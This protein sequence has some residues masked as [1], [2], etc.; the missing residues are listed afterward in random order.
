MAK[1]K[2]KVF[3]NR[4]IEVEKLATLYKLGTFMNKKQG[5][6]LLCDCSGLIKG[7]LWDYPNDGEYES[8][9][10]PDINADTMISRCSNVSTDF[11]KLPYGSLVWLKGH[12]GVHIGNGVCIE[13]SPKWENGIQKT[14]IKGCGYSNSQGLPV[15]KWTKHGIFDKYIDYSEPVTVK[16]P[17]FYKKYNGNS[18][19]IDT[20]FKAIG[21]PYGNVEMRRLVAEKNGYKA[22]YKG[23][24]AQNLK[25]IALAKQ[26]KL[27]KV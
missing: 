3:V 13:S 16:G 12:I 19:R 5:R 9:G 24:A 21:A 23:T 14:F 15:R 4:I 1:M 7:T 18:F 25:L 2:V 8:N 11:Y 22:K 26:G 6:Y 17:L 10:V 27:V 20:V